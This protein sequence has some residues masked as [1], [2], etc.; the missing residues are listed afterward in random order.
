MGA[1]GQK[2]TRRAIEVYAVKQVDH[3]AHLVRGSHFKLECL[4]SAYCS[5]IIGAA[6]PLQLLSALDTTNRIRLFV[7]GIRM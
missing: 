3:S 4:S 2:I 1:E 5:S 7:W 6:S